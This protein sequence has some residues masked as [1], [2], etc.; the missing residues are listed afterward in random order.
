MGIKD[1][2]QKKLLSKETNKPHSRQVGLL[3]TAGASRRQKKNN[4]RLQ[5]PGP[6]GWKQSWLLILVCPNVQFSHIKV[7]LIP[8]R[9]ILIN[10][11]ETRWVFLS[12]NGELEIP[13]YIA[14]Y[15][16]VTCYVLMTSFFVIAFGVTKA[17]AHILNSMF[18][19]E[20]E[21]LYLY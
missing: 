12:R 18:L 3:I 13:T 14:C 19:L 9:E 10:V 2:F 6:V 20:L 7:V 1:Y 15:L 21:F 5:V 4:V 16:L 11:F 17:R 8:L